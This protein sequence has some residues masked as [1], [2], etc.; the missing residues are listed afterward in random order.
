MNSFQSWFFCQSTPKSIG[1]LWWPCSWEAAVGCPGSKPG[2]GWVGVASFKLPS[3]DPSPLCGAGSPANPF[4]TF[5]TTP[6]HLLGSV[7]LWG[8]AALASLDSLPLAERQILMI[9]LPVPFQTLG[10][11]RTFCTDAYTA[12]P[13]QHL[14]RRVPPKVTPTSSN[15]GVFPA[16]FESETVV[17]SQFPEFYAEVMLILSQA[18][19]L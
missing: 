12:P 5:L 1:Q 14:D 15:L 6:W 8:G 3:S 19:Y 16:E 2:T 7:L 17:T 10:F 9:G 13:A 18:I 11:L 4:R